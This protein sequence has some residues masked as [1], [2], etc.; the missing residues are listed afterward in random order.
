M[1]GQQ[2]KEMLRKA[3]RKAGGYISFKEGISKFL[4]HRVKFSEYRSRQR[5]SHVALVV[6]NLPAHAGD[7]RDTGPILG[8]GRCPGEG[9][10][11]P[12]QCSYLEHP[13]DRGAW[14]AIVHRMPKSQ[15]RLK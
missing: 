8:S 11:N 6:K 2:R 9:H 5:A 13:M 1:K 3:G 12:L 14:R 7:I 4:R 15:T 10:G